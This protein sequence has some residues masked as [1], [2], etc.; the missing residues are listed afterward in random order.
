MSVESLT[1]EIGK[2]A[3]KFLATILIEKTWKSVAKLQRLLDRKMQQLV[4]EASQQYVKN[5]AERHCRLKVLGMRESV[6]LESI[7][8]TVF[9]LEN[10]DVRR[11]E[12]VE[13]LERAY[14]ENRSF[15]PRNAI[16]VSGIEVANQKQY[17]MVLGGPG[18]GKSTFLRKIG[19][20]ALKGKNG[21][22]QHEC[23]PVFLELKRFTS[24]KIDLV[25]A[26]IEEFKICGL[27]Y[28]EESTQK[29]LADGR[30]LILFDGLDEV[31]V[32]NVSRVMEVIE[33]FCDQ[34]HQNRFIV[35]CRIAAYRSYF[36]RFTDVAMA[37]FDNT[38]IKQ[39]ISNWF[40]SENDKRFGTAQKCWEILQKPENSGAK[41]LA[42]TPL[43]LTFLCLVYDHSQHFANKRSALYRQAL[44]ILLETWAAEKRIMREEIYKGLSTEL[45]EILLA[46]IAYKGFKL[47]QL[48]FPRWEITRDI[49]NFISNNL[50]VP[51]YLNGEEILNAIAVQQGIL[52][53]RAADIYSFCHLS[54]QEYLTAQYITDNHEVANL[55]NLHLLDKR[56]YE[57]FLLVAGLMR[58][59]VD[60]FLMMMEV[61]ARGY[62]HTPKLQGLIKWVME[63]SQ[64]GRS[65]FSPLTQRAVALFL[66]TGKDASLEL[67]TLLSPRLA[68]ILEMTRVLDLARVANPSY[69]RALNSSRT[70]MRPA[71][72]KRAL[73]QALNHAIADE[74]SRSQILPRVDFN[75][76]M[77]NLGVLWS[78]A[79]RTNDSY[80]VHQGFNLRIAQTWM[81]GLQLNSD[82]LNLSPA[83]SAALTNY[84]YVNALIV[85]CQQAAVSLSKQGWAEVESRM[86]C[87]D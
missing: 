39:F 24:A 40:Q 48:F 81:T 5:Y 73:E 19:L 13:S 55:V 7:Y 61:K 35:S 51:Q 32:K 83:E 70:P 21:A 38:Q 79:P 47:D 64:G 20:E 3:G 76:L 10:S 28:A 57:V 8:I 75:R 50:N 74:L 58:R 15:Q 2:E 84:L 41:E 43:L 6:A 14:R 16:K 31:P 25:Q 87:C 33:N 54:L 9:F 85:R 53:E 72:P 37:E 63:I 18:V 23:I 86:L 52:V 29:L 67:V 82:L 1:T 71:T 59:G 69:V 66:G 80:K 68:D 34:Y 46:D 27:P 22:Y 26:I 44:R 42:N 12:S 11:L 36:Q 56:W 30:L 60:E 45:E 4:Y 17:L 62:L 77:N 49:K 65:E 78:R